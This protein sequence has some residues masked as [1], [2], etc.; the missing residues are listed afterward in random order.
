MLHIWAISSP[1]LISNVG[2]NEPYR[3]LPQDG[4]QNRLF[5]S[6]Q[7]LCHVPA[8]PSDTD[9]GHSRLASYWLHLLSHTVVLW[10]IHKGRQSLELP[11]V[12]Y[13][14][15]HN[16]LTAPTPSSCCPHSKSSS[17][18]HLVTLC[19]YLLLRR[20][21][22]PLSTFLSDIWLWKLK[23]RCRIHGVR[24]RLISQ[25]LTHSWVL[26]FIHTFCC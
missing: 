17:C 25:S 16:P 4:N 5:L 23:S 24:A 18:F 12:D 1:Q 9:W 13:P 26:D 6:R 8:G 21:L 19:H 10:F 20:P 7:W 22:P 3:Q 15:C 11:V 2:E 14:L